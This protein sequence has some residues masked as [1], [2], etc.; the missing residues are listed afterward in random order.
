MPIDFLANLP[1]ERRDVLRRQIAAESVEMRRL[2]GLEDR[3]LGEAI[4]KLLR[5]VRRRSGAYALPHSD[6]G[7]Y[8]SSLLWEV[9]PEIARRLGCKLAP[10]ESADFET[11]IATPERL[12]E[13]AGLA[14]ANFDRSYLKD[15]SDPSKDLC[16]VSLLCRDVANGSPLAVALDRVA[17]PGP[18]SNDRCAR[19][20]QEISARRGYE[21]REA[22]SP[23]LQDRSRRAV[24]L[25]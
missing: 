20:V 15:A 17:P 7:T 19:I 14:I 25:W 1:P 11:R 10:H 8:N 9:G 6:G 24:S 4:L 5:D 12:R 2:H 23:E 18:G 3:W 13:I 16:P 21:P 22:W